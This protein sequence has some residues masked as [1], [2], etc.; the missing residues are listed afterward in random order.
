[1]ERRINQRVKKQVDK[2]QRE[3]YLREQLKAIQKE[4]GE[5]DG[6][7]DEIEEY[8]RKI[9][10]AEL[11]K[12]AYDKAMKELD[13]LSKMPPGSAEVGVI[14]TYLDWIVELPWN[15]ETGGQPGP[16]KC[17]QDTG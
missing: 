14:R 13:R 1:M 7:T 10:E 16:E 15:V 9:E 6:V 11:P 3:Y 4:L 5:R 17:R 8:Q 12:E 2:L